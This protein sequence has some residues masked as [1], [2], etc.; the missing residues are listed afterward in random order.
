MQ[1]EDEARKRFEELKQLFG[2]AFGPALEAYGRSLAE[3]LLE[4]ERLRR[5]IRERFERG[6]AQDRFPA[7]SEY[8]AGRSDNEVEEFFRT[9]WVSVALPQPGAAGKQSSHAP[10]KSNADAYREDLYSGMAFCLSDL[11]SFAQEWLEELAR[12]GYY[13]MEEALG[14]PL[15]QQAD[16][17]SAMPGPLPLYGEAFPSR[18]G[19]SGQVVWLLLDGPRLAERGYREISVSDEPLRTDRAILAALTSLEG[20]QLDVGRLRKVLPEIVPSRGESV[21]DRWTK[22]SEER[23]HAREV[24]QSLRHHQ[25]L[26]YVLA[27]L[28]YH[29]PGFDDL[30]LEQRADLLAETCAYVNVFLEALRKLVSFLEHGLP[31]RRGP[32]PTRLVGRDV[33]A[34]ILKDVDGLTYREVARELCIPLPVDFVVKGD[35]PAVRRMVARG[36]EV[37][38]GALGEEGWHRQAEAMRA[39]AARWRSISST[40]Q[41]A[42][43]QSEILSVPYEE[44]LQRIEEEGRRS[45]AGQEHKAVKDIAP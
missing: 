13:G 7:L 2:P 18:L 19:D 33:K 41:E 10:W 34:T 16:D 22:A 9:G 31:G 23:G 1:R 15:K 32:V 14:L 24:L 40:E 11:R 29:R 30:P 38:E 36:R 6:R 25:A 5:E 4:D 44:T 27:L 37:L 45:G 17:L 26:D 20:R 8:L 42:E 35:S 3:R 39:E 28:R 21:W 43:I 12:V